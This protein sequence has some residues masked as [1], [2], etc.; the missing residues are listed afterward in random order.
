M[1]HN[2]IIVMES[3]RQIRGAHRPA[4]RRGAEADCILLP[5]IPVDFDVVYEHMK[6]TYFCAWKGAMLGAGTSIIV[7]AEASRPQAA[8][9][10]M[11]N[12]RA[13]AFGHKKLAGA[14]NM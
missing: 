4:R 9:F 5:E 14:G 2:R 8:S 12:L 13:D 6:A 7:A 3:F 10:S 1:S 11:T